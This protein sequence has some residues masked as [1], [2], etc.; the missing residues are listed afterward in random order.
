MTTFQDPPPQ[1]RRSARQ[2]ER[3]EQ[4]ETASFSDFQVPQQQPVAEQPPAAPAS[5]RRA[6]AAEPLEAAPEP[7]NYTTQGRDPASYETQLP[8]AGYAP[9]PQEPA[10]F[11]VRDYSPEGGGRR[12]AAPPPLIEPQQPVYG[13]GASDLDYRTQ[14]GPVAPA[15]VAEPVEH[16]TLSRRELR[17]R[18]AAADAAAAAVPLIPPADP[19]L[20]TQPP[21]PFVP[22]AP[23]Q[24]TAPPTPLGPPSTFTSPPPSMFTTPPPATVTAPPAATVT[25]PPAATV[26]SPPA[27]SLSTA[28]PPP[29]APSLSTA[30]PPAAPSALSNAKSEFEALTR[31]GQPPAP[32]A[33]QRV[34]DPVTPTF[35]EPELE[36]TGGWIAP[37]G[38]WSRQADLDDETQP[39][40]NT[41][42]REVG[43]GNVATTTSA[44]VLPEIPRANSFPVALDSTGEVLL[45]GSI[46]LPQSLSAGNGDPRRYDDSNVDLMF[47]T[48][49]AE[50]NGTDSSPVRAISAVSTHTSSRGVIHAN[51]PHGNRMIVVV[52]V[53][54]AVLAVGVVGM[55]VASLF[56]N[57]F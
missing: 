12:A 39:W 16:Q 49:D 51:K 56:M 5:G 43:G 11:R 3:G 37:V 21:Q 32:N 30:P 29:M 15:P 52:F 57:L 13:A 47:D 4:G 54:T 46:D 26:T 18:Q 24:F 2:S 27:A 31:T 25:S 23:Q 50:F 44:L 55:L 19:A 9:A 14:A 10:A 8:A 33:S 7:L 48:Q 36:H 40:E 17:E 1:S 35:M 28:P 45:T 6:R 22:A 42:T 41:I 38:H 34:A 53:A 20:L